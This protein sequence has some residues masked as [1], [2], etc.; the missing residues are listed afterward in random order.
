MCFL[1]RNGIVIDG[2]IPLLQSGN[3]FY[4]GAEYV[5]TEENLAVFQNID[6]RKAGVVIHIDTV[7]RHQTGKRRK[8]LDVIM[9]TGDVLQLAGPFPWRKLSDTIVRKDKIGHVYKSGEALNIWNIVAGNIQ[10]F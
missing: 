7:K 3:I 8:G 4:S 6:I 2:D 10:T 5:N 9:I 1:L